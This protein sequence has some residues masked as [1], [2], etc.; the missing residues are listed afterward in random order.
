MLHAELVAFA[1]SIEQ[2]APYPV[3]IDQVLHGMEV[4]DAI[5]RSGKSGKVEAVE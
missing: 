5:V 1:R 2:K 4:F 3:P